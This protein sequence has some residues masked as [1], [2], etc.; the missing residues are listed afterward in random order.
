MLAL[1]RPSRR[2]VAPVLQLDA[3]GA[4]PWVTAKT[5]RPGAGRCKNEASRSRSTS[6]FDAAAA[7]P[8]DAK[9]AKWDMKRTQAN[10]TELS[11]LTFLKRAE[12]VYPNHTAVVHGSKSFTWRETAGAN[13]SKSLPGLPHLPAS[14]E[15]PDRISVAR[16]EDCGT[17]QSDADGWRAP[18]RSGELRAATR[19][20]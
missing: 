18:S 10:F 8:H 1:L 3:A 19:S 16:A 11:P 9:M 17:L 14:P 20:P 6:S 2:L 4:W 7:T 13:A 12:R 5:V 15:G